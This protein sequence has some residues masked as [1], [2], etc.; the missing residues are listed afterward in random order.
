MAGDS[1]EFRCVATGYPEPTV[2]WD[3]SRLPSNAV[4]NGDVLTFTG[5][6]KANE[7]EYR[8]VA[9]NSAG[10]NQKSGTLYVQ[11]NRPQ[12]PRP[13]YRPEP[14]PQGR[15][16]VEISPPSHQGQPGEPIRLNCYST[17]GSNYNV[18]WRRQGGR[19]PY[20]ATQED[21]T[22]VIPNP[23]TADSGVYICVATN[24]ANPTE[25]FENTAQITI[26]DYA[27][28]PPDSVRIEPEKQTAIQGR[29]ATLTC[30]GGGA[31][32]YSWTRVSSEISILIFQC[33]ANVFF[34]SLSAHRF[35]R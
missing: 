26:V 24:R 31:G 23:T 33:L 14:P 12:T 1:A 20:G 8:C 15:D 3:T 9:T 6:T 11:D 7:G 32:P 29:P 5:V 17:M 19:L 28:P 18:Q 22:L 25:Q 27:A 30:V 2:A 21:G 4:V 34:F 35:C 16:P 10:R 13:P